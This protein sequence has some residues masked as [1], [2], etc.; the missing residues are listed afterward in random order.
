MAPKMNHTIFSL[1]EL[2]LQDLESRSMRP[3]AASALL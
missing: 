1:L 2:E 3:H